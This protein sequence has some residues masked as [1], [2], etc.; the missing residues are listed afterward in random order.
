M[1]RIFLPVL[2]AAATMTACETKHTEENTTTTE[3]A[4]VAAPAEAMPAEA[5]ATPAANAAPV[6]EMDK[7]WA[8]KTAD[9]G[10]LEVKSSEY[11]VAN[12]TN[13]PVKDLAQMMI[14]DHT[15]ANN[16]LMG[17]ATPKGINLPTDL[18]PEN[19]A[20][21]DAMAAKK[22]AALDKAYM[23]LMDADHQK[24]VASFKDY[25][26]KGTDADLKAFA[27]KTLPTLEHHAMMVKEAK[28]KMK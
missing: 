18:S 11:A 20:K 17:I 8:M 16:E 1:K 24:T 3:S 25:S 13:Q 10:M 12:S 26:A 2:L 28:G 9:G 27:A 4:T 14:D 7:A 15:R 21:Y 22:G 5:S 19:K 23:E 6:A